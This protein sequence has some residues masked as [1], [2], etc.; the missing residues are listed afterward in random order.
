MSNDKTINHPDYNFM[1]IVIDFEMNMCSAKVSD[2]K[3]QVNSKI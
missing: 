3:Y 2:S 1:S